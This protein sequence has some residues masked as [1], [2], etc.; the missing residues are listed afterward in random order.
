M[1][2][3]LKISEVPKTSDINETPKR[4]KIVKKVISDRNKEQTEEGQISSQ[5]NYLQN[6][7]IEI[8]KVPQFEEFDTFKFLGEDFKTYTDNKSDRVKAND[9]IKIAEYLKVHKDEYCHN[10]IYESL[11]KIEEYFEASNNKIIKID[12]ILNKLKNI[13]NSNHNTLTYKIAKG[14]NNSNGRLFCNGEGNL[15]GTKKT[16]RNYI[17]NEYCYDIDI[18]NCHPVLMYNF[19]RL[20]GCNDCI[21]FKNLEFYVNNRNECLK[22]NNIDKTDFLILLYY[23]KP[24]FFKNKFLEDIHKFIYVYLINHLKVHFKKT[25]DKLSKTKKDNLEGSFISSCMCQIENFFLCQTV[26]C[27]QADDIKIHTLMFDGLIVY[28]NSFNDKNKDAILRTIEDYLFLNFNFKIQFTFKKMEFNDLITN[29]I[30]DKALIP[31]KEIAEKVVETPK[32]DINNNNEKHTM[33]SYDITEELMKRFPNK[34]IIYEKLLYISNFYG[35]Y[36]YNDNNVKYLQDDLVS[37]CP[38]V[39]KKFR[40]LYNDY[41]Y[42]AIKIKRFQCQKHVLF[43]KTQFQNV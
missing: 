4:S 42:E 20:V 30:I 34:Y 6:K 41:I 5:N 1:A 24:N 15:Q 17:L 38:S 27:L 43:A 19:S 21:G 8:M 12:L 10:P 33:T 11:Y 9:A 18:V 29:D 3:N 37:I 13:V 7:D 39:K 22:Q 14:N 35:V 23:N 25:F 26:K 28:Q 16:F 40:N 36:I 2:K 32:N 31:V